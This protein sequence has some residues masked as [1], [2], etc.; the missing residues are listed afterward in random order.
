VNE[1]TI[2][3]I[4][5]KD[6]CFA[7]LDETFREAARWVEL[8]AAQGAHLAVLP[9]TINLLHRRD[10]SVSLGE[11]AL[12][13]WRQQTAILCETAARSKISLILPI[14]VRDNGGLANRFYLI[15]SDGTSL[16]F[17]QKRAPASGE[18]ASGVQ[19]GN[20][21][22]IQWEGLKIGG[23]ICVDV[24]YPQVVFDPQIES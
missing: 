20:S 15:S 1:K 13:D 14:L 5:L 9:E 12:E 22:P 4:A 16:G 7:T 17:Y 23:A 11:L 21:S 24:F 8:A 19:T 2:A 3:T 6:E 10:G 18:R